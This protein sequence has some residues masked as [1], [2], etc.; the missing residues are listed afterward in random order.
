MNKKIFVSIACFMDIDIINTI[1]DCLQKAEYPERIVLGICLQYDPKD[2]FLK[3]YDNNP[4][5]KIHRIN[6]KNAKGPA[7][8][9]GILYDMFTNEDYFFQIDCHTR[10]FQNWDTNIINHYNYCLNIHPKVIISHYP[11]NINN[12]NKDL[13]N[14][15]HISTVRCIDVNYG[16]KTHGRFIKINSNPRESFGISGAMLFFNKNA[17]AEVPFDKKIYHGLQFEEQTVLAARYW[18]HGY[19]IYQMNQHVIGTEYI[20]NTKRYFSSTSS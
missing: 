20:T 1:E 15:G 18:T 12:M 6:W 10:F 7:F 17:Y 5:C 16:I 13:S 8:A 11:I 19:N 9:R 3:S 2:D 14:I 4:Q